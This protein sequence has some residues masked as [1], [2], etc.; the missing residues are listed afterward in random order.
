MKKILFIT[1]ER[2]RESDLIT[3]LRRVGCELTLVPKTD[4]PGLDASGYDAIVLSGGTENE[5]MTFTP[6]V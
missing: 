4:L 1:P 3:V 5:P 2:F 6:A